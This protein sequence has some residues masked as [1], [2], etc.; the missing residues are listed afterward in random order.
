MLMA[1]QQQAGPFRQLNLGLLSPVENN[2]EMLSAVGSAATTCC[3]NL[4]GSIA[5]SISWS[6][7]LETHSISA[8]SF[9]PMPCYVMQS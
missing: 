5:G 3:H 4:L 1:Q 8:D 7:D 2:T 9:V 6:A